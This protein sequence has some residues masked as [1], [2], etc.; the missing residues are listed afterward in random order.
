MGTLTEQIEQMRLRINEVASVEN[1][2][3]K[4][5]ADTLRQADDRLLKQVRLAAAEHEVRRRTIL[6][7]LEMLASRIGMCPQPREPRAAIDGAQPHLSLNEPVRRHHPSNHG[8]RNRSSFA[9]IN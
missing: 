3:V 8:E 4:G 7:E 6:W 2:G 5:L 1:A 9:A